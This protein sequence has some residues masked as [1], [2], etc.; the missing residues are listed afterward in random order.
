MYHDVLPSIGVLD[1]RLYCRFERLRRGHLEIRDGQVNY[2]HPMILI[3]LAQPTPTPGESL[4]VFYQH[5]DHVDA[6]ILK[7]PE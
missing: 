7:L 5:D 3:E 2:F 4:L 6:L 1:G